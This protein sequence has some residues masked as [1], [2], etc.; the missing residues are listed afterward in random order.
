MLAKSQGGGGG[1]G[2]W[3]RRVCREGGK[4]LGEFWF[5]VSFLSLALPRCVRRWRCYGVDSAMHAGLL[6][7]CGIRCVTVTN[8][9]SK[10]P[11]CT[12][13]AFLPP[14]HSFS[15][16]LDIADLHLL[17][18]GASTTRANRRNNEGRSRGIT[19]ISGSKMETCM[20][21]SLL[22][23]PVLSLFPSRP[24]PC[25]VLSHRPLHLSPF[26][27]RTDPPSTDRRK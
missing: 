26:L 6:S 19:R 7:V 17:V 25:F 8:E 14:C 27:P 10:S 3:C 13:S 4:E 15:F 2:R 24:C 23:F 9:H 18:N 20:S 21:F 11:A 16:P 1:R 22:S 12:P 5:R